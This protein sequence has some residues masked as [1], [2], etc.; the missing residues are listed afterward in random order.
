M[1]QVTIKVGIAG[2]GQRWFAIAEI[3]GMTIRGF[4]EDEPADAVRGLFSKLSGNGRGQQIDDAIIAVDLLAAGQTAQSIG[5]APAGPMARA[6]G[7]G[8]EA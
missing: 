4:M 7:D 2:V 3:A 1:V 5:L 8:S 6:L